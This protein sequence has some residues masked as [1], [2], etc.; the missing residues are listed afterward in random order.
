VF[1]VS[2]FRGDGIIF[3]Y[4]LTYNELGGKYSYFNVFLYSIMGMNVRN[5][6]TMGDG[7]DTSSVN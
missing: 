6:S 2:Q 7:T 5:N 4:N 3:P 1:F